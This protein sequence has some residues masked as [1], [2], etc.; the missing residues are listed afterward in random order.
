MKN[1][2][3]R[4]NLCALL[5]FLALGLLAVNFNLLMGT[6]ELLTLIP[7]VVGA[8]Q[9]GNESVKLDLS[10]KSQGYMIARYLGKKDRAKIRIQKQDQQIYTYDLRPDEEAVISFSQGTGVYDITVL[11]HGKKDLYYEVFRDV[12]DVTLENERL[13]FLYPNQYVDFHEED[14]VV[15][16]SAMLTRGSEG[17]ISKIEKVYDYITSNIAYDEHKAQTAKGDIADYIPN[18]DRVLSE[19]TG[20]CFDYAVLMTAML[21]TSGIPAKLMVGEVETKDGVEYHSWVNAYVQE[22]GMIGFNLILRGWVLLDP[23]F[24]TTSRKGIW[25]YTDANRY[26]AIYEY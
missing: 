16:L 26:N 14:D 17:E 15:S 20:M 5:L 2:T 21:R 12:A 6:K 25:Y 19:K 23:T 9:T 11:E 13:P 10:N 18:V 24:A 7:R 1:K 8:E 4:W 3:I 22:N